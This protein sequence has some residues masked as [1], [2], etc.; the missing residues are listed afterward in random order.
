MAQR[1]IAS[2]YNEP[3]VMWRMQRGDRLV[4][5]AVIAPTTEGA[6]VIWFVNGRPLGLREFNDWSGAISWS[7]RIR[8]QNWVAGWRLTSDDSL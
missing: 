7:D 8:H 6:S 3:T 2:T 5:H 4:A 1:Q